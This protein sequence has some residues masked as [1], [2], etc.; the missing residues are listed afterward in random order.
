VA[1]CVQMYLVPGPGR[2]SELH[3]HVLSAKLSRKGLSWTVPPNE[4]CELPR[5]QRHV[6]GHMFLCRVV[7]L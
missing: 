1:L 7:L 4:G 6:E 3:A 2:A 5:Q